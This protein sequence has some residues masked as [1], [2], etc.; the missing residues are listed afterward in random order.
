MVFRE[1]RHNLKGGN[2]SRRPCQTVNVPSPNKGGDLAQPPPRG[3][4]R[5]MVLFNC[6][7]VEFRVRI[8]LPYCLVCFCLY[9]CHM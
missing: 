4:P 7:D 2:C 9:V 6:S 1:A 5:A 3:L 8:A